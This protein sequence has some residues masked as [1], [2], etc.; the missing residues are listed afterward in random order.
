MPTASS[1]HNWR[2]KPDR[3]LPRRKPNQPADCH[4]LKVQVRPG[5]GFTWYDESGFPAIKAISDRRGTT[6]FVTYLGKHHPRMHGDQVAREINHRLVVYWPP[7][8]SGKR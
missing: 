4:S 2:R 5:Q 6:L 1:S 3:R 7:G 8:L